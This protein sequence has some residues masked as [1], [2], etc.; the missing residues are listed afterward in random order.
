MCL[1][2]HAASMH[3]SGLADVMLSERA[4]I[5][6]LDGDQ[7]RL[8]H[9]ERGECTVADPDLNEVPPY[10]NDVFMSHVRDLATFEYVR[11]A[12][13]AHEGATTIMAQGRDWTAGEHPR[14]SKQHDQRGRVL[15]AIERPREDWP[16]GTIRSPLPDPALLFSRGAHRHTPEVAADV[17]AQTC[18]RLLTM[19]EP[20]LQPTWGLDARD[21][22]ADA[23][24]ERIREAHCDRHTVD[25]G[26]SGISPDFAIL[27][28][29]AGNTSPVETDGSDSDQ[30][31][32]A[33]SE[34]APPPHSAA[35]SNA[36]PV[37][38]LG[39]AED[40]A[41]AEGVEPVGHSA[42]LDEGV[43][44][45][46]RGA[47]VASAD[48]SATP[49]QEVG[50]F[51]HGPATVCV[52]AAPLRTNPLI[53]RKFVLANVAACVIGVAAQTV[54]ESPRHVACERGKCTGTGA[55]ACSPGVLAAVTCATPGAGKAA[56]AIVTPCEA[57]KTAGGESRRVAVARKKAAA[58]SDEPSLKEAMSGFHR[59]KWL[60]ATR[61]ELASLTENGVYDSSVYQWVPRLSAGN[62]FWRSSAALTGISS[63]LR[64]G[65]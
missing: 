2:I 62:G 26:Y 53:C 5:E 65:M 51:L 1:E 50:Q 45:G 20:G 10:Q 42:G 56:Q 58:Y 52:P 23:H 41:M 25:C 30:P 16:A 40:S 17:V 48:G 6:Q 60:E 49:E 33:P 37:R 9:F 7:A 59:D 28:S 22:P 43:A 54:Y 63:G 18:E 14:L 57:V 12:Q 34:P 31:A 4:E 35:M 15:N 36:S 3:C 29:L 19:R 27:L 8:P 61:D 32:G 24:E 39:G 13:P 38:G 64:R 55:A 46:S 11:A 21:P 47:E 44:P